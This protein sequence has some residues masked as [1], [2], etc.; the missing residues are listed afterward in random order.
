MLFLSNDSYELND[1]EAEEVTEFM[2]E[3]L[4]PLTEEYDES[5]AEIIANAM[6]EEPDD[7]STT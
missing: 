7:L 2:Q 6:L 5:A 1:D 4:V 3:V